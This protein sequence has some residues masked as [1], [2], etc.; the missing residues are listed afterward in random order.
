ME[1]DPLVLQAMAVRD[2]Q[3]Q[4]LACDKSFEVLQLQ[5]QLD[6]KLV[7]CSLNFGIIDRNF[8]IAGVHP[9]LRDT[10][11]KSG[12]LAGMDSAVQSTTTKRPENRSY[13][14]KRKK[15]SKPKTR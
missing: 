9:K 8:G 12:Y 3:G 10:P 7:S 13:G 11:E 15:R 2:P 14:D 5:V 6:I 4:L 1:V